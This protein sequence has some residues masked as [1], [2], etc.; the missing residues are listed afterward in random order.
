MP[1]ASPCEGFRGYPLFPASPCSRFD[2]LA[3]IDPYRKNSNLKGVFVVSRKIV[4]TA[5]KRNWASLYRHSWI[6]ASLPLGLI[7]HSTHGSLIFISVLWIYKL[8]YFLALNDLQ[9]FL[10]VF[11]GLLSVKWA[12]VHNEI[13]TPLEVLC[14]SKLNFKFL[15]MNFQN[16][17]TVSHNIIVC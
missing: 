14:S 1:T 10:V 4:D 16:E 12:V 5:T 9:V 2:T 7:D 13:E 6:Q 3:A 8:L 15:E 17:R 11:S